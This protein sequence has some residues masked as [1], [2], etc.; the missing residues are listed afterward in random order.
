[1][2]SLEDFW[3][4]RNEREKRIL[5]IGGLVVL[6]LLIIGVVL[7]LDH[8][9][10][11]AH[12]RIATKRADLEWMRSVGPELAASGPQSRPP[13]SNESLLVT[14]DRVAREAGLAGALTSSEPAGDRGLSVR[15]EKAS[16]DAVIGWLARLSDRNGIRVESASID[17]AGAPGIVNV[18]V[19][20]RAR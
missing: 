17:A 6:V 14:V 2:M 16:F 5:T 12:A 1:M 20:L 9:V 13:T 19:T 8:S 10:A 3:S 7:P 18:G 15:L 4:S 11:A